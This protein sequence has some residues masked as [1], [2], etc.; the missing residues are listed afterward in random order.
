MVFLL[1]LS[2]GRKG[3]KSPKKLPVDPQQGGHSQ[4]KL[5]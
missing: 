2:F 4:P 3:Q 1:Q 5:G